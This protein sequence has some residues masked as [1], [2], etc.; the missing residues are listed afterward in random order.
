MINW[1]TYLKD[2]IYFKMIKQH[3][4]KYKIRKLSGISKWII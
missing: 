4:V 1:R 3:Y 2:I